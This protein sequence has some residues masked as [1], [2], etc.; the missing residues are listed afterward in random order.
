MLVNECKYFVRQPLVWLAALMYLAFAVL[1]SFGVHNPDLVAIK[2]FHYKAMTLLI[3]GTP[4][5]I[6]ALAPI[7]FLRDSNSNMA[8]LVLATP[9]QLHIHQKYRASTL[10]I[11]SLLVGLTGMGLCAFFIGQ[12]TNTSIAQF[13]PELIWDL[14]ILYFP[15]LVFFTCAAVWLS[16]RFNSSSVVY[17]VFASLWA[18]YM[19]VASVT[20]ISIMAGSYIANDS[21][22]TFMIWLDP[23]GISAVFSQFREGA[24]AGSPTVEVLIN[25]GI[26]LVLAAVLFT[27][28]IKP[29][30][31]SSSNLNASIFSEL[32]R[33]LRVKQQSPKKVSPKLTL[34]S[35][36][37]SLIMV[38]V[39]SLA[40]N[41]LNQLI[42]LGWFFLIFS[43][44]VAGIKHVE[45]MSQLIP[46]SIDAWNRIAF[47]IVPLLGNTLLL[48]WV[49]QTCWRAKQVDMSELIASTPRTS[50]QLAMSQLCSA[51]IAVTMILGVATIAVLAAELHVGSQLTAGH[52]PLQLLVLFLP[53]VA[54]GVLFVAINTLVSNK[55]QAAIL[56]LSVFVLK[57]SPLMAQLGLEHPLWN[58][59]GAPLIAPD[60]VWGFAASWSAFGPYMLFWLTFSTATLF[61]AIVYSHRGT[62]FRSNWR[63]ATPHNQWLAAACAVFCVS[64]TVLMHGALQAQRPL[65]TK[66]A[67]HQWRADYEHQFGHWQQL[68]QPQA[69][70][71][72]VMGDFYP[73]LGAANFD[74]EMTLTNPHTVAIEQV[75]IGGIHGFEFQSLTLENARLIASDPR[76][77]QHEFKLLSPLLPN[78]SLTLTTQI[79]YQQ[80]SL[81]P[82]ALHQIVTPEFSYFR[83]A[84]VMPNVGFN[85]DFILRNATRRLELGLAE[86]PERNPSE[87]W[88]KQT[89]EPG[90]LKR[91]QVHSVITTVEGHKVIAPGA[92][93]SKSIKDERATF[94]FKTQQPIRDIAAWFSLPYSSLKTNSSKGNS[95]S[96]ELHF[97]APKLDNPAN[98][99]SAQINLQGMKDT[100]NWISQHVGA[101]PGA[102]LNMI[103]IPE[104]GATGYA[105]PHTMLVGHKVAVRAQP[106]ISNEGRASF[107]H[108][109]RRAVHETAHQ[110]FGHGLGNGV[111]WDRTFLVEAIAKYIELVM[112]EQF[113]TDA[114]LE[115]LINFEYLRFKYATSN[116]TQKA[117]ALIDAGLRHDMYSRATLAFTILREEI[118]DAA[119]IR[120]LKQLWAAN[121]APTPPASSVDF[122]RS[123]LTHTDAKQHALIERLFLSNDVQFLLEHPR[124]KGIKP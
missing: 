10:L 52:Y 62:G 20:G 119:I 5:L 110:W 86:L 85:T 99:E 6:G 95:K 27:F 106:L 102:R 94:E 19:V 49:W 12:Q 69:T 45:P 122:V 90:V 55:Y 40:S 92:L 108:R 72:K 48:F 41:R 4:L 112:L 23:H 14:T 88:Q 115:A 124:F 83:S 66:Q 81:W 15:S 7:S 87:H 84:P 18:G 121:Q 26:Y 42:L 34:T 89:S 13:V 93:V 58:I 123:L 35:P 70:A 39:K 31:H 44:V 80:P 116:S 109:Y 76:L 2:Q 104:L 21:L 67:Q 33:F 64:I 24:I 29:R 107:D 111:D 101:Y 77:N 1:V 120:T 71:M 59:A 63:Q 79:N 8:E 91:M 103:A 60:T 37:L 11:F 54:S 38:S 78:Q 16:H 82:A 9:R 43:E 74:I 53:L 17:A 25:R 75:L 105:M 46:T 68:K 65:L 32:R 97:Y 117:V 98:L 114:E 3:L 61:I 57:F 96:T 100:L 47:D 113:R 56:S 36:M 22:L 50:M 73:N 28:A 30:A 51:I 118:G